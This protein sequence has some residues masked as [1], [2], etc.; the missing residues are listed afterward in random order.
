M[1]YLTITQRYYAEQYENLSKK[2][3]AKF[4][5]QGEKAKTVQQKSTFDNF[6]AERNKLFQG[7]QYKH[8]HSLIDRIDDGRRDELYALTD[9]YQQEMKRTLRNL[10]S[11]L[12][13]VQ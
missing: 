4:G 13:S 8:V 9:K 12:F 1:E 6:Q 7:G 2:F 10:E 11:M 5:Q 3:Y